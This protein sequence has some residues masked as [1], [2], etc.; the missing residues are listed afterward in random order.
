MLKYAKELF[1]L[2]VL[3]P[4]KRPLVLRLV[5]VTNDNIRV[6]NS[7]R[8]VECFHVTSV[9]NSVRFGFTGELCHVLLTAVAAPQAIT[10]IVKLLMTELW[11]SWE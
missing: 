10:L 8:H 3:L 6:V 7:L 1:R 4:R 5:R 2:G 9:C 11:E